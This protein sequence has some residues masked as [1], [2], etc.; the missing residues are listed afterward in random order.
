MEKYFPTL[1]PGTPITDTD[2]DGMD[3][4]WERKEIAKLGAS[5]GIEELKPLSYNISNRYTNLEIYMNELVVN[6]FPD[7]ANANSTR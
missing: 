7:A 1:A 3:D 5:V 2:K 4:N 6:T